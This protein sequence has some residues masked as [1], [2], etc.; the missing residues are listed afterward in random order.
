M[1]FFPIKTIIIC[2][3]MP[4]LLYAC[5][6]S[7]LQTYL[8]PI[9]QKKIEQIY[10]GD[11]N[12]LFDGTKNIHDAVVKNITRFS[13]KDFMIEK[14]GINVEIIITTS[15]GQI[16]YPAYY[17]LLDK[18]LK[19]E[20][21][22]ALVTIAR[23]NWEIINNGL[24]INIS[25]ELGHGTKLAFL[26]LIIY[27]SIFLAIF[28]FFY[29]T[30]LNKSKA[31]EKKRGEEIDELKDEKQHLF[32]NIKSLN[33]K[34]Q[35]NKRKTKINEDEMFLEIV[36]LE[37]KLNSFIKLK[38]EKESQAP[39]RGKSGTNKRKTYNFLTKRM[40][41]LYTNINISRKAMAS[42]N[43]LSQEM[44]IKAEEIIHQLN[45]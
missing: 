7:L 14:L 25:V 44:Q 45:N 2:L 29:K 39:E 38:K 4:P 32:D 5:T 24:N 1:K 15:N 34:Y 27:I 11:T 22:D 18:N 26:I 43:E 33:E 23:E 19:D 13:K 21:S 16:I 31:V 36:H 40:A 6:L 28:M 41:V 10:L 37:E 35:N 12:Q 30:G 20:L 8:E 9:Y 3:I 17:T 42:F